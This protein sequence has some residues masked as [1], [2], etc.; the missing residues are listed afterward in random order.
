MKKK[1]IIVLIVSF[2]SSILGAVSAVFFHKELII[3]PY[4]KDVK[5]EVFKEYSDKKLDICYGSLIKCKNI[6]YE[7]N[8]EV[9][10]NNVGDNKL[11]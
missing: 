3:K 8:G 7:T 2:I 9:D 6:N 10:I 5:V 4:D 11:E 1:V